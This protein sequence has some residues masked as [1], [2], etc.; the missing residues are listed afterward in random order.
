MSALMQLSQCA[1]RMCHIHTC[2]PN[3]CIPNRAL[4][5]WVFC[6]H[7]QYGAWYMPAETW[8]ATHT[9][10]QGRLQQQQQQHQR[11]SVSGRVGSDTTT[12]RGSGSGN[13]K[14]KGGIKTTS[15]AAADLEDELNAAALAKGALAKG[16]AAALKQSRAD[17]AEMDR[18]LNETRAALGELD[19]SKAY[20]T[21][22]HCVSD[23]FFGWLVF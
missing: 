18:K 2:P 7:L 11:S 10:T 15:S 23:I 8:H 3:D 6:S 16:A 4:R 21:C 1:K 22:A 17:A 12:G 9:T 13:D 19:I 20:K 14:G 5:V